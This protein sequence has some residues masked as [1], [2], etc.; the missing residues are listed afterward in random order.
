ME[1]SK[2]RKLYLKWK[3]QNDG[4]F[5]TNSKKNWKN[6]AGIL[7]KKKMKNKTNRKWKK[8]GQMGKNGGKN[9][10][11]ALTFCKKKKLNKRRKKWDGGKKKMEKWR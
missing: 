8:L 10:K 9:E 2:N 11:M 6:G 3:I 1:N 5:L 4:Q 7:Q